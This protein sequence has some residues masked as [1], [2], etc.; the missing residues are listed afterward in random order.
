MESIGGRRAEAAF[1]VFIL[2]LTTAQKPSLFRKG[3]LVIRALWCRGYIR[4][5]GFCRGERR[6]YRIHVYPTRAKAAFTAR[7]VVSAIW[8]GDSEWYDAQVMRVLDSGRKYRVHYI[9]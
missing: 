9:G 2:S 7:A 5:L 8:H 1:L 4:Q 3:D 6:M